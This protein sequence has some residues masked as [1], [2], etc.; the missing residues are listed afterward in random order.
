VYFRHGIS[1]E[2]SS[3]IWG[4]C[5]FF[6]YLPI[7]SFNHI[8]F[9]LNLEQ[10]IAG[11]TLS[12]DKALCDLL[13]QGGKC[14]VIELGCGLQERSVRITR[15]YPTVRYIETDLEEV[16]S[17][18][19]KYHKNI[20]S[21]KCDITKIDDLRSILEK[22]VEFFDRTIVVAEGLLV[23]F[24]PE[25]LAPLFKSIAEYQEKGSIILLYETYKIHRGIAYL[26]AKT[27]QTI[28][29]WLTQS[30]MDILN[31]HH[32]LAEDFDAVPGVK[33]NST[34]GVINQKRVDIYV[35]TIC[36]R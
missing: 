27:F 6:M 20:S 34:K 21:Q 14:L 25:Q 31:N 29:A 36:A 18:K 28:L 5:L 13:D 15:K 30:E 10:L 35:N 7:D 24:S 1:Q 19:P 3:G 12:I 33:V 32:R 4:K 22:N 26:I 17:K 16:I 9:G 11:R 23:Y 2:N 8:L